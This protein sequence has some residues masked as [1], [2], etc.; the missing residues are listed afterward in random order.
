MNRPSPV[1]VHAFVSWLIAWENEWRSALSCPYGLVWPMK[2]GCQDE[3]SPTE[4]NTIQRNQGNV[5]DYCI[6][7]S[8]LA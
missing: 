8:F 7:E 5:A 2:R 4:C 6:Y 1:R 3:T